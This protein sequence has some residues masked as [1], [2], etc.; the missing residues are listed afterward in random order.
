MR[1]FFFYSLRP[2]PFTSYCLFLV[3]LLFGVYWVVTPHSPRPQ[4]QR[5]V[6]EYLQHIH[7]IP[8]RPRVLGYSRDR[9]GDG[10]G[11]QVTELGTC[12]TRH[13][14]LVQA[15][16]GST[17]GCASTR[18]RDGAMEQGG[19]DPYTH[20]TMNRHNVDVDHIVPLAAAWDLGAYAWPDARRREFANDTLRNLV[21][22]SSEV[23]REKSDSTLSEWLPLVNQCG[24]CARFV[25]V[26]GEYGLAMTVADL[27]AARDACDL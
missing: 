21:L 7:Q 10:W 5:T 25:R 9:F 16:G 11:M 4:D 27:Q 24:Y 18:G 3:V 15:F 19:V 17:G 26:I 23:N 1:R 22:T 2:S 13:L 6:A 12:D 8:A 20:R 14:L